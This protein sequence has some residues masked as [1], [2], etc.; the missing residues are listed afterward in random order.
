MHAARRHGGSGR[1]R[2]IG[3]QFFLLPPEVVQ[4]LAKHGWGLQEIRTWLFGGT[5]TML[6][7][8]AATDDLAGIPVASA[9]EDIHPVIAGGVGI[10]M[11]YLPLWLG[12]TRSVTEPVDRKSTRLNSSH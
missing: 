9:P 2:P 5:C 8:N 3:E 7:G 12:G 4:L 1:R 11:T 6:F 10:K